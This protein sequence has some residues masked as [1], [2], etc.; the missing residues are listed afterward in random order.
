MSESFTD[1]RLHP[2]LVFTIRIVTVLQIIGN[3]FGGKR[4][5]DDPIQ[6][7]QEV[8]SIHIHDFSLL[9]FS[10]TKLER[11]NH[12]NCFCAGDILVNNDNVC[13]CAYHEVQNAI[14]STVNNQSQSQEPLSQQEV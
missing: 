4:L 5:G 12:S 11:Q 13:K 2:H 10:I 7:S 6:S 8:R 3:D 14:F 1:F 9:V